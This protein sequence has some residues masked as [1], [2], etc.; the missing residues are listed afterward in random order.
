MPILK[1]LMQSLFLGS[2]VI[3]PI[4]QTVVQAKRAHD[5]AVISL[6]DTL[7][8]VRQRSGGIEIERALK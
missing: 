7:D 5:E 6:Q 2:A 4:S 8:I 1:D 3:V